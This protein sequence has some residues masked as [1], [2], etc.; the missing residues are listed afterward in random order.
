MKTDGPESRRILD[1]NVLLYAHDTHDPAR[2]ERALSVLERAGLTAGSAV[3]GQVLAEFASA[4][5]RRLPEPLTPTEAQV[6]VALLAHG[7]TTFSVTPT[8]I[9]EA[10]RGVHMYQLSFWDA[11]IWATA[12][13]NRVPLIL[14]EDLPG[15]RDSVETVRYL[16]PLA[17]SFDVAR[18][19][20]DL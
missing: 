19:G 14:T 18:I 20:A 10:L 9:M 6:Q 11:L 1:T 15:G 7:F 12:Q 13:E 3:T 2:Q 17:P 8:C 4:A 5:I 16:N